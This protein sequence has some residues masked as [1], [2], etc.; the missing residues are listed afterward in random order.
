MIL[1]T[2]ATGNIGGATLKALAGHGTRMRALSRSERTWPEGVEGVTGDLDD[3][4][5][6]VRAAD[7]VEAVFLLS[8]YAGTERLL[9]ALRAAGA[10][11]AV[12]LSSSSAPSGDETNA[13]A[14]Y[15]IEAE[16]TVRESG[17]EWTMLQPNSFMSNALQW[18]PQLASGDVV[19]GPFG[20]VPVAAVDPADVG[21]VAA[22]ALTA[23][24]HAGQTYRLSGPESLRPE[25]QIAI[26]GRVLDRDLRWDGWS[27]EQA[28]AELESQMPTPYVDAFF[29]FF[30][31][32]LIDETTVRSTVSELLGRPARSFETWAREHAGA[33][34]SR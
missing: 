26:L 30:A 4:E 33:F 10:T 22:L 8:G 7:G 17:L 29:S 23:P 34:A 2:G 5:S 19:R 15:H 20:S 14:R 16:R 6:M 21:A 3:A 28:R 13:V 27:D 12:L 25:Q 18:V 31:D 9:E 32:G 11:R 24:G 1:I